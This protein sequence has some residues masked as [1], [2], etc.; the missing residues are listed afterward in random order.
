MPGHKRNMPKELIRWEDIGRRDITEIE[1][2][3]NLHQPEGVLKK[4]MERA[5]RVFGGEKVYFLVNGSTAGILTAVSAAAKK[6]S[7]IIMARNCHK[8]VYHACIIRELKPV[9]LYPA[10]VPGTEFAGE[11]TAGQVEDA[12]KENPDAGTVII[13]SPTYDGVVSDIEKIAG[14]VHARG[15]VLIVDAAHGAHLGLHPKLPACA[16]ACGADFT[17]ISLHK[18]LPSLTQT[19]LLQV[20]GTLVDRDKVER[21]EGIYQ[22]SSPSYLLM[23][24][25]DSCT[26]YLEEK[27]QAPWDGFFEYLERFEKD[28][29]GLEI[30]RIWGRNL[31]ARGC[32]KAF[33]PGKLLIS[34]RGEALTGEELYQIL[35]RKYHLQ[36]EMASGTYVT[37]IVTAWDKAEGWQR[38]AGALREIDREIIE[39]GKGPPDTEENSVI[40]PEM[41][42]ALPLYEAADAQTELCELSEAAGRVAV[43]FVNLYPP[44]IPL[45]V[46][47]EIISEEA[48]GL[49]LRY[50]R[51][52]LPVQG[53]RMACGKPARLKCVKRI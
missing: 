21:Y 11:I 44:G 5:A 45:L 10:M 14:T 27:G 2:F 51:M 41:H 48:V 36:M 43:D 32:M 25:I 3:D 37:A 40:Y 13:T 28:I 20:C 9:Y 4:A 24:S 26:A 33:D 30:L 1:G 34:V 22:T 35:L 8:S 16:A 12:L 17:I 19:A 42:S 6:G 46:P 7:T 47:G 52:G 15:A 18:T 49:L 53:L 29:E 23:S 50:F 38:L 39:Q 31:K